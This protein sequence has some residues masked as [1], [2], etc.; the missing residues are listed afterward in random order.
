MM[1]AEPSH[2]GPLSLKRHC[3]LR[4]PLSRIVSAVWPI[5]DGI[6]KGYVS[7]AGVQISGLHRR[8]GSYDSMSAISSD[9]PSFCISN[10]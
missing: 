8:S 9:V 3:P 6:Q 2:C 1:R 7:R 4:R 5:L 10:H